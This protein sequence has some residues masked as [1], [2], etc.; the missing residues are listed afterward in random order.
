MQACLEDLV[1]S[2]QC[3]T[4][5]IYTSHWVRCVFVG[6]FKIISFKVNLKKHFI[7][8][9]GERKTNV[10]HEIIVLVGVERLRI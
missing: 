9:S 1:P 3:N 10:Y 5:D 7:V 6:H 4:F 2:C 8:H